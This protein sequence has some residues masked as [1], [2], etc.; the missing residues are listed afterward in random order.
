MPQAKIAC[1]IILASSGISTPVSDTD[2]YE[3]G[4]VLNGDVESMILG[5]RTD[6]NGRTDG[7]AGAFRRESR[8]PVNGVSALI[9]SPNDGGIPISAIKSPCGSVWFLA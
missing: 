5:R 6:S 4:I 8:G 3:A 1:R 9:I 7:R 2:S